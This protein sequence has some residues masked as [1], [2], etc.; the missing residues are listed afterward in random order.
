MKPPLLL[1]NRQLPVLP[2][3]RRSVKRRPLHQ[4]KPLWTQVIRHLF[5]VPFFFCMQ[6]SREDHRSIFNCLHCAIITKPFCN[7]T[8]LFEHTPS[9]LS[10][11]M[12]LKWNLDSDKNIPYRK[13]QW[14]A[15]FAFHWSGALMCD[16]VP[17]NKWD[18]GRDMFPFYLIYLRWPRTVPQ[19]LFTTFNICHRQ[20]KR[21]DGTAWTTS[22]NSK[23]IVSLEEQMNL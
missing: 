19:Y 21:R 16:G 23:E 9:Y 6:I 3:A 5:S 18:L 1:L 13:P 4:S 11:Y 22:G 15:W 7:G 17:G 20:N 14:V 10:L 2:Q 8:M 12:N